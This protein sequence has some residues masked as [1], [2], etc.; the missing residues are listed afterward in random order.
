MLGGF[1]IGLLVRVDSPAVLVFD[2]ENI[3]GSNCLEELLSVHVDSRVCIQDLNHSLVNFARSLVFF[4]RV[5]S[6]VP[7]KCIGGCHT[8]TW[9]Y[10][11]GLPI[12]QQGLISRGALK[13]ECYNTVQQ[14]QYSSSK[15][16]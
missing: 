9:S 11:L 13:Y 4:V 1:S 8:H 12:L 7:T 10:M 14:Q 3:L 15:A 5:D 6:P 16:F 2:I